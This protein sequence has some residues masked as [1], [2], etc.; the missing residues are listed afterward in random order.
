MLE[1]IVVVE[2]GVRGILALTRLRARCGKFVAW[3]VVRLDVVVLLERT[4][5]VGCL[6]PGYA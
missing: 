2:V 1:R 3:F 4:F 5:G 6:Y